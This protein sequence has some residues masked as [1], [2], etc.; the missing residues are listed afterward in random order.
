MM[1]RRGMRILPEGA[2][3]SKDLR[4]PAVMRLLQAERSE[5]IYPLLI[6]EIVK[7]GYPRA[8]VLTADFETGEVR[9]KAALGFTDAT[10]KQFR[11]SIYAGDHPFLPVIHGQKPALIAGTAIHN[12]SIYCIPILYQNERMCWEAER[13]RKRNCLA[14]LN[15]TH[16][17]R[18]N[19]D[20]QVCGA[21]QMRAYS[22][23]VA[24]EGPT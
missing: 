16:K 22:G 9:A 8:A 7:I 14:Q 12:K 23:L 10:V 5:E 21:C 15:R 11:F 19:L 3:F 2:R 1:A 6:E 17:Q 24:V 18:M 4:T 13:D 20:E